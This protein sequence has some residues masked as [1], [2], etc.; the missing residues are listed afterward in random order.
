MDLV[1][2]IDHVRAIR[3]EVGDFLAEAVESPVSGSVEVAAEE[4][5]RGTADDDLVL[6]CEADS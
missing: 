6:L 3:I 4:V 5:V 2:E 1:L